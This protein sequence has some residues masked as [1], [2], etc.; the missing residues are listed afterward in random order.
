MDLNNSSL[1]NALRFVG[2]MS[3]TFWRPI[4]E[5]TIFVA[6]NSR[7]KRAELDEAAV[8]TFYLS[9]AWQQND[10]NDMQTAI[11]NILTGVKIYGISGQNALVIRG[12]QDELLLAQKMINDMDKPRP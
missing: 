11:R 9:N 5:N 3:N 2:T 7:Q 4:S 8:Q 1:L 12:T 10:L 6:Q